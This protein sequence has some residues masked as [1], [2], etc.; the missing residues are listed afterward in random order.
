MQITAPIPVIYLPE[1]LWSLF[2]RPGKE[3]LIRVLNIEGKNLYL[4]L[5]GE[6]FQAR[7]GGTLVPEDFAIGEILRVK[8][9]KTG[10]PIILQVIA[11]EKE[12][13]ELQFLYLI[14][15]KLG[16][17]ALNKDIFQKNINILTA[18]L[19][20]LTEI[21]TKEKKEFTERELKNLLGD[22]IKSF[23]FLLKGEEIIIPFI[24]EDERSWGFLELKE[25]KE[26]QGKVRLFC[27]KIFFEY[28]GLIECFLSY[29]GNEVYV[30]MYFVNKD[31]FELAQQEFKNLEKLFYFYKIPA[32]INLILQEILPGQILEKE[33]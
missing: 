21:A 9:V 11:P 1:N 7:I 24:F 5:G 33:G 22:K 8:V 3:L 2:T 4:E 14:S 13:S 30:D 31:S 17:K 20:D 26:I 28:L 32:R 25:P 19:K 12:K 18:F 10:T 23:S 27:F 16:E 29:L 6:K 15:T